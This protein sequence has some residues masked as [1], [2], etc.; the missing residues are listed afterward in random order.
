MKATAKWKG[1]TQFEG[2]SQSGH[3]ILFDTDAAHTAGPSPM[4]AVLTA[5]CACT[6]VDIV[7][8]LAKK[9]QSLGSLTVSAEAEQ[10]PEAPR[11]FPRIHVTYTVGSAVPATPLNHKAVEDAVSLSEEKYCSVSLMLRQAVEISSSITYLDEEE[12]ELGS[13]SV[14]DEGGAA[15]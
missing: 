7:G 8:I 9:R 2:R 3:A 10:A 12:D 15:G 6:S 14:A 4:E 1:N 11:V 5:L 13:E